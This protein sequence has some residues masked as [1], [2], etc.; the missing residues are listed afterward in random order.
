MPMP[1]PDSRWW[2]TTIQGRTMC[3]DIVR[4]GRY[5]NYARARVMNTGLYISVPPERFG[6]GAWMPTPRFPAG[7]LNTGSVWRALPR[8]G[9]LGDYR[10]PPTLEDLVV[11][12]HMDSGGQLTLGLIREDG[13]LDDHPLYAFGSRQAHRFMRTHVRV[14]ASATPP[15]DSN[16][17]SELY[18]DL[19]RFFSLIG[20]PNTKPKRS[21]K[22]HK[23]KPILA[24]T[25]AWERLDPSF[26]GE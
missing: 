16:L 4:D 11:I 1:P 12:S 10:W 24:R 22:K 21:K 13:S 20:P 2:N 5:K 14:W 17:Q 8:Q 25:S 15:I 18:P 7:W 19:P 26:G 9:W 23:P 6:D 3:I